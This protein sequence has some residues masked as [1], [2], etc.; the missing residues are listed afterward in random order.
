M[1]LELNEI[2]DALKRYPI[3]FAYLFGSFAEG[4]SRPWSDLD[5]ALIASDKIAANK[6]PELEMD[7]SKNIDKILPGI[8][9]DVRIFNQ[10]PLNYKIQVVQNGKLIF[11]GNEHK[12]VAFE[13][14]V[15]DEYFDFLPKKEE[16]R[17]ASLRGLEQGGLLWSTRKK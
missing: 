9:N 3:D 10:A 8:E 16:Y 6:Y 5:I 15:R 4:T 7:I 12:R 11:S 1:N 17:S 14:K 2:K 13:T